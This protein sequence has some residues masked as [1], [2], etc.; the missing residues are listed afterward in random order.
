MFYLTGLLF[1]YSTTIVRSNL[2][3]SVTATTSMLVNK[4]LLPN[5]VEEV[6]LMQELLTSRNECNKTVDIELLNEVSTYRC[7]CVRRH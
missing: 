6:G 4:K 2:Y 7:S 1:R 5:P 3:R